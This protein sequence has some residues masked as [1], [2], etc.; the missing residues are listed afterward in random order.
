MKLHST[1]AKANKAHC[2]IKFIRICY[3]RCVSVS[4]IAISYFCVF[5]RKIL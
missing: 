1:V 2:T 4:D 3:D 5:N